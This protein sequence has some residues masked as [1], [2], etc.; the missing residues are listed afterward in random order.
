MKV[1]FDVTL[2]QKDMYRFS[3]YH[4]YSGVHGI[5][6][7]IIA[8]LIFLVSINT[9]GHIEFSYTMLYVIFGI[10]FLFYMPV[11]LYLRA[12]KQ[13]LSSE[14]FKSALHYEV[15]EE[16]IKTSQND[17]SALL[18]WN[19]IYKIVSTK[20]NVL[21]YSNRVNAYVIPR[22]Q[23]GTEYQT[24]KEIAGGHLENYRFKMK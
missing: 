9:Y 23:I 1:E 11:N 12:K 18:P 4:A 24:L 8:V 15:N 13:L 7:I 5:A 20:H 3:M 10:V 19:Q 2:E 16:G 22:N 6:S 14:V 21:V 17:A